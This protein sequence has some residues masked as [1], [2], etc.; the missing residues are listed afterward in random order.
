MVNIFLSPTENT[1]C[2]PCPS[3]FHEIIFRKDHL[4]IKEPH[5]NPYFM[6][7]LYPQVLL[8]KYSMPTHKIGWTSPKKNL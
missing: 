1:F 6:E 7:P 2:T 4:S 8:K 5:E 3:P